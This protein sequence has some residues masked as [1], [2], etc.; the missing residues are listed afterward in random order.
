MAIEVYDADLSP[1]LK[2]RSERRKS[3]SM[4]PSQ[5]DDARHG[6]LG[7]IG[8]S[9][10]DDLMRGVQLLQGKRVVLDVH[11]HV[12]KTCLRWCRCELGVCSKKDTQVA[13][14]DCHRSRRFWPTP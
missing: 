10:R 9:T 6:V 5:R 14:T 4:I 2:C 1:M 12:S 11:A 13:S 8:S 7:G 3:S